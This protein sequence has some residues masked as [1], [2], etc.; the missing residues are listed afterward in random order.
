LRGIFLVFLLLLVVL[1]NLYRIFPDTFYDFISQHVKTLDPR[2]VQSIIWVESNFRHHVVSPAGAFGIMQL[3]PST[4]EWLKRK[5]SLEA[6]YNDPHGNILYGIVYLEYLRDMY[7]DL[8]KAIMAYNVGPNALNE[9]RSLEAAQK[10]LEKV[11]RI[12]SIY[13]FLYHER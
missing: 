6:S 11:K 9:G 10:Y 8:D 3:M 12:Y 13:R 2:L 7:G 5:F 1:V 4:A